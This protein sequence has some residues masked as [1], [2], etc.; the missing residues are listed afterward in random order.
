MEVSIDSRCMVLYGNYH[1]S[2]ARPCRPPCGRAGVTKNAAAL[3]KYVSRGG[4]AGR[5]KL[6]HGNSLGV[7]KPGRAT[8]DAILH[9]LV[10]APRFD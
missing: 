3:T 5:Q 9:H 1:A 10:A 4:V 8:V 6:S 7:K 2:P